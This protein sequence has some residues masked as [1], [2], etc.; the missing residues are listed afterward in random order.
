MAPPRK[1]A[2]GETKRAGEDNSSVSNDEELPKQKKKKGN[3][4]GGVRFNQ[5]G[6]KA[7]GRRTNAERADAGEMVHGTYGIGAFFKKMEAKKK[8]DEPPPEE[9]LR[10]EEED[11][12]DFRDDDDDDEESLFKES[13]ASRAIEVQPLDTE[14]GDEMQPTKLGG[15]WEDDVPVEPVILGDDDMEDDA[16]VVPRSPGIPEGSDSASPPVA[17]RSSDVFIILKLR[18][19]RGYGWWMRS[20]RS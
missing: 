19:C 1:R 18:V 10:E 4:H 5:D 17:P 12:Q 8:L 7:G 9:P 6:S 14:R 20:S 3:N 2:G 16:P 15:L 11:L 13:E